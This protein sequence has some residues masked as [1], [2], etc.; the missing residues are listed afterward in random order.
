VARF[1]AAPLFLPQC[2][3]TA[4]T[5]QQAAFPHHAQTS[6]F[7]VVEQ[8]ILYLLPN[9]VIHRFRIGSLRSGVD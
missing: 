6:P 1:H 4:R 7:S 3:Q 2:P 9:S 8:P 5:N